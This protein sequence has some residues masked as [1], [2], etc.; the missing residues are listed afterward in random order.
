MRGKSPCNSQI[1]LIPCPAVY[2]LSVLH[3]IPNIPTTA[4]SPCLFLAHSYCL[5]GGGGGVR[6]EEL[7]CLLHKIS[8]KMSQVPS[9]PPQGLLS[10][11]FPLE[12]FSSSWRTTL[13]PK[14][15][16]SKGPGPHLSPLSG[17]INLSRRGEITRLLE[18]SNETVKSLF[19]EL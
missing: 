5:A 1:S 19:G 7:K 2:E 18:K 15:Y 9:C 8:Q 17:I 3:E 10:L 6:E 13:D 4:F 11:L 14:L 16:L 12:L